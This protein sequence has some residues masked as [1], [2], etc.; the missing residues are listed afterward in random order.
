MKKK[1][2]LKINIKNSDSGSKSRMTELENTLKKKFF[3]R[4][5]TNIHAMEKR[6]VVMKPKLKFGQMFTGMIIL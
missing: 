5:D 4:T 1:R 3:H 2:A 6:R